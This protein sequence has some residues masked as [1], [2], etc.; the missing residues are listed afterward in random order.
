MKKSNIL[1]YTLQKIKLFN[2]LFLLFC[3]KNTCFAQE[4]SSKTHTQID[5]YN[6]TKITVKEYECD[7]LIE[8]Q[9]NGKNLLS[10]KNKNIEMQN[11]LMPFLSLV[12]KI[13]QVLSNQSS[14]KEKEVALEL[15]RA[16]DSVKR[17]NNKLP[18]FLM[19]ETVDNTEYAINNLQKI[20]QKY[21][22]TDLQMW[23]K[24]NQNLYSFFKVSFE[25]VKQQQFDLDRKISQN[26]IKIELNI[27]K[28]CDGKDDLNSSE[29]VLLK[30]FGC[31]FEICH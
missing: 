4:D 20:N 3:F 13:N 22:I 1:K 19:R 11:S 31:Q 27:K 24:E 9:I 6:N 5:G 18:S 26:N 28:M 23:A 17:L 7:A 2:L 12:E 21:S 15:R 25:K 16:S 10:F 8:S 14:F 30:E 29:I